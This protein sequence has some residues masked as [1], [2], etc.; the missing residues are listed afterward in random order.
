ME[1]HLVSR[2]NIPV[3]F[4]KTVP[5]S[6]SRLAVPG[7]IPQFATGEWGTFLFYEQGIGD[8]SIWHKTY[9]MKQSVC[10]NTVATAPMYYLCFA[11]HRPLRF[12][13]PGLARVKLPEGQFNMM[14][15]A[16]VHNQLWFEKGKKYTVCEIQFAPAWLEKLKEDFSEVDEFAVKASQG[17]SGQLGEAHAQVTP[18]MLNI[19]QQMH[20]CPFQ[21]R[22]KNDYLRSLMSRLMLLVVTRLSMIRKPAAELKLLPHELMKVREIQQYLLQHLDQPGT[23]TELSHRAGL[24]EFKLKRGFRQ[25]YAITIFEFLLEA[26][27][28][29]AVR[30]LR[31]TEMKVHAVAIS[32][33]YKNISS[34]T[35]AFKKRYGVLP[36]ELQRR[37]TG[38]SPAGES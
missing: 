38:Q 34:F 37:G 13:Q 29:R 26:R 15:A 17:Y 28:E 16:S 1:I 36:S 11:I 14:H 6:L 24:N 4:T 9:I 25:L 5:D 35:V 27:M 3:S 12:Q 30:L 20:D 19:L 31:E 33:G 8:F 23:V 10:L 21:G 7:A 2:G 18:G 22:A 32:V